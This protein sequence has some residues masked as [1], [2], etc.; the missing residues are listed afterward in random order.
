MV[1]PGQ[2]PVSEATGLFSPQ[3]RGVSLAIFT[4]VALSAFEGL[5]VAAALPRLAADLG[6]V[7]LL[8]WVIT[9]YLLTSGVSTV[10]A[11][12][13]V[14]RVGVATVFRWAVG[15]FV[16]GG[17]LAGIAPSMGAVVAARVLQGVGSG[18]V[19]AVG[20]TAVGLVYPPRLVAR[21]FAA[22]STV[23]GAMSVAGPAIAAGL[24]AVASWRW[25]FLVNLPLGGLAL[26]AGWRVMP[27]RPAAGAGGPRIRLDPLVLGLVTLIT[28]AGLYAVDAL[29]VTSLPALAVAVLVGGYLLR[30]ERGRP[31]ALIAPRHVVD[32]PLGPLAWTVALALTGAIGLAT[33]VP[34]YLT[35][36]RGVS[37]TAAAWSVVFFTLGWT[38]GANVSSRVQ[39]R[40]PAVR[41]TATGVAAVPPLLLGVA[42][43]IALQAPL[44]VLFVPI[45]L[46]GAGVGTAT[47]SALT[48]LRAASPSAELGRATAAHQFVRNLGFAIGNALFG[49]VIL[50]VV[51]ASTGR[52][53]TVRQVLDGRADTAAVTAVAGAIGDGFVVALLT[54]ALIA[55]TALLPLRRLVRSA[56]ASVSA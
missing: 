40:V 48:I 51:T 34:L 54:G 20:L 25:I 7:A 23:W 52:A 16:V 56:P 15:V 3:L 44:A 27:S 6:G 24:L 12:A 22:N 8:P 14:D 19:N 45:T 55:T 26:A 43:A 1:E 9:A 46:V 42:A 21:A 49:G 5:A 33:Y 30:R 38:T 2:G 41:V 29:D 4:T 50:L 17:V 35:A 11:G 53:E 13:L 10:A 36:G 39:D 47:N 18:A 28:F 37:T 32:A 31:G